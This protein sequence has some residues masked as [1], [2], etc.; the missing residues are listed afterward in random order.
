MRSIFHKLIIALFLLSFSGCGVK[1]PPFYQDEAP[2]SD[3]NV[4]FILVKPEVNEP[5]EFKEEKK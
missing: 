1:K 5:E 3:E 2:V 4:E